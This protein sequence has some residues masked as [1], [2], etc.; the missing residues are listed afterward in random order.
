MLKSLVGQTRQ[1]EEVLIVGE[2]E[3]NS[4]IP[5]EFPQ[6]KMRFIH[7]PGSSISEARNRGTKKRRRL[8]SRLL[9]LWMMILCWSRT[10][11]KRC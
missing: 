3:E 5:A 9:P 8:A 6:L 1:P 4:R 2:G 7:L 11:W 10:L